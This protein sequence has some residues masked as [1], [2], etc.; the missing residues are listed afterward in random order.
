MSDGNST[1]MRSAIYTN[2]YIVTPTG[3]LFMGGIESF[4]MTETNNSSYVNQAGNDWLEL[5]PGMRSNSFNF[6]RNQI[7]GF[8]FRDIMGQ[9]ATDKDRTRTVGD[10]DF[11]A[12]S[13]DLV[14]HQ[15]FQST[16]G[17]STFED[18]QSTLRACTV[19]SIDDAFGDPTALRAESVAGL[20]KGVI[21][22]GK[23]VLTFQPH[24]YLLNGY[25]S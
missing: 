9:V 18:T 13:F 4:R 24:S 5:R 6:A 22:G 7:R 20:C 14:V 2:L 8:T 12:I 1:M 21:Y 16:T 11:R 10:V 23:D 3:N 19:T 15:L 25:A 17:L